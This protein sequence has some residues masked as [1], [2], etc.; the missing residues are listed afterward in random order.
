MTAILPLELRQKKLDVALLLL[1]FFFLVRRQNISSHHT[2][3]SLPTH[4]NLMESFFKEIK[5]I[6]IRSDDIDGEVECSLKAATYKGEA[7]LSALSDYHAL[8]YTLDIISPL[9]IR[10]PYD[11]DLNTL[12]YAPG[13]LIRHEICDKIIPNANLTITNAYIVANGKRLFPMP[14]AMAVIKL[15]PEE[16]RYRLAPGKKPNHSEQLITINNAYTCDFEQ[17]TARYT[18]PKTTR[19]TDKNG[20]VHDALSSGQTLKGVI[21]GNDK[22]LRNLADYIKVRDSF[23][24]GAHTDEGYGEVRLNFLG[25]RER[26]PPAEILARQFDAVCLSDTII[27]SDNGIPAYDANALKTEIERKLNAP[28]TLEI[29]GRYT[30][31][32][33]DFGLY[34]DLTGNGVVRRA[35]KAGSTV[36]FSVKDGNPT[37]IS[38]IIHTF[39]GEG[40]ANG[41]GEIAVY[42]ARGGYYRFTERIDPNENSAKILSPRELI[43]GDKLIR[44]VLTEVLKKRVK[45]LAF[46]DREDYKSNMSV[47]ELSPKFIFEFLKEEY[48]P[49]LDLNAMN[50]WYME[51]LEENHH[52]YFD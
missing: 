48:N 10:V 35:I 28:N 7:K 1:S 32:L 15:S 36:R 20:N 29:V 5:H 52:E 12:L 40:V 4:P 25:L 8:D 38:P 26:K 2:V 46:I 44:Y 22:D 21:Y 39:V 23:M 11:R 31:A 3:E 50:K 9:C 47:D 18:I 51:E 45:F 13:G 6:G 17:G 30:D 33:K 27:L 24:L 42:P 49:E 43:I 41:Y 14:L 37:D 34:N 19:I 16:M